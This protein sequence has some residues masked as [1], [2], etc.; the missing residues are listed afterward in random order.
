MSYLL[1]NKNYQFTNTTTNP[2]RIV[3][4]NWD[5][6]GSS[7]AV[8]PNMNNL[9][10]TS[11]VKN[12]TLTGT[13]KFGQTVHVTKQFTVVP[14]SVPEIYNEPLP[15]GMV[16]VAFTHVN[17]V[18]PRTGV[19][20]FIWSCQPGALP[21]GIS[22][23]TTTGEISGI[24]TIGGQFMPTIT[25]T[26]S[27]GNSAQEVANFNIYNLPVIAGDPFTVKIVGDACNFTPA[28]T[29][30]TSVAT[31]LTWSIPVATET[32]LNNI[33]LSFDSATGAISGT[34]TDA[35]TTSVE[36]TV[37]DSFSGGANSDTATYTMTI[38]EA[39][40]LAA[41][42]FPD[43]IVDEAYTGSPDIA[44]AVSGGVSPY[45]IDVTGLPSGMTYN[46]STGKV[47]GTPDT[48]GTF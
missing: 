35:L 45:T 38:N 25:V 4:W 37:T 39:L 5:V 9:F 2:A 18:I 47:E 46:S 28:V 20:P 48:T 12:I 19:G 15:A 11:G 1:K 6:N 3:A 13:D 27:L 23:N 14:E 16:G 8:T 22:L 17:K 32:A 7:I 30:P 10:D 24:P 42:T 21:E 31:P 44:A 26:D 36:F 34:P 43:G 40:A 41:L 33:G 29:H